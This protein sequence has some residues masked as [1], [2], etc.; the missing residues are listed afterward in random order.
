MKAIFC[1]FFILILLSCTRDEVSQLTFEYPDWYTLTSPVDD[2]IQ[3]IWG[4]YER[5]IIIATS[6]SI[7]QSTDKGVHWKQVDE[8]KASIS[9]IV[10]HEDTLFAMNGVVN[11][12][13]NQFMA[14]AGKYSIDGGSSWVL[15]R[16]YNPFFNTNPSLAPINRQLYINQRIAPNGTIYKINKV[17]VDSTI[18]TLRR[19]ETPGII[20]GNGRKIDV[21][22]WHQLR[23]L[24]MDEKGRLYITATDA[25]CDR[26]NSGFV[27][28]NS[29]NGRGVI[30]ISKQPLP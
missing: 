23:S 8:Q 28:C 1:S 17:Y 19:Y 7:Y 25:I 22:Q 24:Y 11:I 20:T 29:R 12:G 6:Y 10:E 26:N 3:G 16:K 9:G 18:N 21:P 27:F 2:V 15:Y 30:Y 5:N 14:N 13:D 4:D